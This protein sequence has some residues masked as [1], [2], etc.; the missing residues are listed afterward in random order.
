MVALVNS[1]HERITALEEK[2]SA[3][4]KLGNNASKATISKSMST[5]W[6]RWTKLRSTAREQEK[7]LEEALQEWKELSDKVANISKAALTSMLI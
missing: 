7:L 4:E 2:A 6:Q 3:M 5:V 1:F